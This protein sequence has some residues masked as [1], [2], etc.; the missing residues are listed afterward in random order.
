MKNPFLLSEDQKRWLMPSAVYFFYG[1][2]PI[3]LFIIGFPNNLFEVFIFFLIFMVVA[4][5][6]LGEGFTLRGV[7]QWFVGCIIFPLFSI[8]IWL[9]IGSIIVMVFS[10]FGEREKGENLIRSINIYEGEQTRTAPFLTEKKTKSKYAKNVIDEELFMQLA[11]LQES[12]INKAIENSDVIALLP[13]MYIDISSKRFYCNVM[14]DVMNIQHD[15][16]EK[17]DNQILEKRK[18]IIK[19]ECSIYDEIYVK[20][21]YM[22]TSAINSQK[23]PEFYYFKSIVPE[24]ESSEEDIGMFPTMK[25]CKH[26]ANLFSEK[27]ISLVG[28]C[29]KY[30]SK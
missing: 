9:I 13:S 7:G 12:D 22:Y 19:T 8:F 16:N 1:V 3:F 4:I 11:L 20:Y 27:E 24:S 28:K 26:Y 25:E 30:E 2:G 29:K 15:K 5:P 17:E 6:F 21:N 18:L 10:V 14:Q 23:I